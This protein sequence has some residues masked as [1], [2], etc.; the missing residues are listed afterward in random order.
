[1]KII[2]LCICSS[3]FYIA[4]KEKASTPKPHAFPR[5]YYPKKEYQS[6]DTNCPYS[7]QYPKY[8]KIEN[9]YTIEKGWQPYWNNINYLP[10]NATLH[11]SYN[12]FKNRV[13]FDSLFEDTRKLAY[14]H[15]IKADDIIEVDI[16]NPIT[17]TSGLIFD[18]KGNTST[19]LNFYISD[20]KKHFLRGA[21]YFNSKTTIDS[22]EPVFQFIRQDVLKLIETTKWKN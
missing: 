18:L 4:C 12:A 9:L 3:L 20:G 10:F 6:F 14:K 1:M 11:L 16:F 21:L 2:L 17:Q 15:T 19:N 7:F 5:V 8:A 22:I 13:E